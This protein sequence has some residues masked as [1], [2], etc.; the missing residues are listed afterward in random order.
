[1][2]WFLYDSKLRHERVNEV[3]SSVYATGNNMS[4]ILSRTYCH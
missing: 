2:D 4:L 3:L 1:M